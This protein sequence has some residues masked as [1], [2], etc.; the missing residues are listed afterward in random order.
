MSDTMRTKCPGC[1]VVLAIARP[2]EPRNAP[3]PRCQHQIRIPEDL[4]V[5]QAEGSE[6]GATRQKPTVSQRPRSPQQTNEVEERI[7]PNASAGGG[8][9]LPLVFAVLLLPLGYAAGQHFI[10]AV[11]EANTPLQVAEFEDVQAVMDLLTEYDQK[12]RELQAEEERL[13]ADLARAETQLFKQLNLT[14]KDLLE[15]EKLFEGT[16][17]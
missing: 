14:R 9:W 12:E 7:V 15:L 11:A 3:C 1:E 2:N 10:P 16:E 8:S 13:T 17:Q 6:R 5:L 4:V